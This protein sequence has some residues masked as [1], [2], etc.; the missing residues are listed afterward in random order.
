MEEELAGRHGGDRKTEDFQ[1][2]KISTL[3]VEAPSRDLVGR[4]GPVPAASVWW[5][6]WPFEGKGRGGARGEWYRPIPQG[7]V[8][9]QEHR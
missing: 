7:P 1:E 4:R 8:R 2:G 6:E 3:K 5:E 9:Y